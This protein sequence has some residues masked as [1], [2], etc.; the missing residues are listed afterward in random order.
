[1]LGRRDDDLAALGVIG[2]L[3]GT[4]P[5]WRDARRMSVERSEADMDD[6]P[7]VPTGFNF[8]SGIPTY[9]K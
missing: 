7:T 9:R 6:P 1:M 3:L 5:T 2:C 8:G 4:F